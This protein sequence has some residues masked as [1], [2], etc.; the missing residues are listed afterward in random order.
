M[1]RPFTHAYI[2]C[3]LDGCIARPDGSLDWLTDLPGPE[4]EDYGYGAFLAGMDA[5]LMGRA[6]YDTVRAFAAWPYDKPV[7]VLTRNPD[8]IAPPRTD[9][10]D[11]R[12]EAPDLRAVS[13]PVEGVLAAMAA[14]GFGRVYVDGGQTI[15]ALVRAG[16]LDRL[17]LTR[18]PV[19]LGAGVPLFAATGPETRLTLLATRVWPNGFVQT[20][21]A[22]A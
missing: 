2:A 6:T 7:R 19:L 16:L 14:E 18:V 22:L 9:G 21:Y 13:G 15:S 11:D 5:L 12:T 10:D 8:A 17:T 3:S 20:D 1:S 4:G